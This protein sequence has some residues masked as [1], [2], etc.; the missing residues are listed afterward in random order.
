MFAEGQLQ[1]TDW[2][3]RI[4]EA[5]A[6]NPPPAELLPTESIVGPWCSAD[7]VPARSR[8]AFAGYP[9]VND[10]YVRYGIGIQHCCTAT[11]ALT[12]Y[13]LWK[14]IV[15][16]DNGRLRLNL[17]MNHASRWADVDS[18][19][20]YQGRVEVRPKVEADLDIRIPEWVAPGEATCAVNGARRELAWDGRYAQVGPVG[21]SD[22]VVLTFPIGERTDVVYVE[23]HRYVLHAPWKRRGRHRSPG[24]LLPALPAAPLPRR[25]APSALGDPL[26]QQR[27]RG[28]VTRTQERA[29][30]A[31]KSDP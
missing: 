3:D 31:P 12:L 29:R 8:G 30:V 22:R 16:R 21:A 14:S 9:A 28:L 19:L 24:P 25:R 13:Q 1:T 7:S 18:F 5:D 6:Y 20:P 4:T 10:W 11:S 23:K 17:L 26:R 27:A 2:I 15:R